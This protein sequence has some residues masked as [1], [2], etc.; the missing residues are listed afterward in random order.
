MSLQPPDPS[1]EFLRHAVATLAYRAGKVLRGAPPDFGACKAAET[2]RTA[3]E[4]LAHLGDLLDW[5]TSLTLGAE[6][7]NDSRPGAWDD[8]VARF[9]EGLGRF[10][11]ALQAKAPG[12]STERL[13]QGPVADALTHTG[14]LALL[15]RVAGSPVR[16]ENYFRADILAGRVGADQPPPR[17]EF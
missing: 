8:D 11:A 2:S 12:C 17:R 10:D 14:Q 6:R 5:A 1:V 16:A 3:S 13:F 15:R 9:F 7:W 4:S